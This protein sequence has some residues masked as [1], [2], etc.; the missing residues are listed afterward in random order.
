MLNNF[1]GIMQMEAIE[2]TLS[3]E[4]IIET[5]NVVSC[6]RASRRFQPRLRILLFSCFPCENMTAITVTKLQQIERNCGNDFRYQIEDWH[7]KNM[8]SAGRIF[9]FWWKKKNKTN[10]SFNWINCFCS[11]NL[12]NSNCISISWTINELVSKIENDFQQH[13][14]TLEWFK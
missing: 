4:K 12:C 3:L 1:Y 10:K 6:S 9:H 8:F 2:R 5:V 7:K 11:V 13:I 14:S